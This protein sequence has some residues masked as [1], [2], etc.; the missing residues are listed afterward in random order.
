LQQSHEVEGENDLASG[1]S[2]SM[3]SMEE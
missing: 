2:T 3:N 1:M